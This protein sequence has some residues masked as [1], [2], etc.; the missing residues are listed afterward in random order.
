MSEFPT[1]FSFDV[2]T[3]AT[4]VEEGRAAMGVD[5]MEWRELAESIPPA[6]TEWL[7]GQFD[8]T[9]EAVAP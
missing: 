7:A 4:V 9:L 6:Y 1:F 8:M 3:T 2:E 5:W